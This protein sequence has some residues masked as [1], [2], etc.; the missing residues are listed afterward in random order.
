MPVSYGTSPLT[1]AYPQESTHEIPANQPQPTETNLPHHHHHTLPYLSRTCD[2]KSSY[3][4]RVTPHDDFPPPPLPPPP[5]SPLSPLSSSIHP[6]QEILCEPNIFPKQAVAPRPMQ[7][8][9]MNHPPT[10]FFFSSPPSPSFGTRGL[11]DITLTDHHP[12]STTHFCVTTVRT[13]T[14]T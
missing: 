1:P 6:F 13:A 11:P 8:D 3:P 12:T 10:G 5:S 9:A 14:T 4:P 7:S 2:N